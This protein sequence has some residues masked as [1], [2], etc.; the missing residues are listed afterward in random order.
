M[1]TYIK[2]NT[3]VHRCDSRAKIALL[4]AY[5][6]AIFFVSSWWA[7]LGF[8]AAVVV[9]G[10]AARLPFGLMNRMLVPV[11]VLAGFSVLFNVIAAPIVGGLL[12]GLFL[13]LRMVLLVA[14]SFVVC[15]TSSS[16]DLLEAF[17]WFIGPLGRVHVPVDDVAFT[18]SLALRFIPLVEREYGQIR[19]AQKARGADLAASF[20]DKLRIAG[21][22]FAAM[23]VNLFRRA[24]TM[25]EAM[26]SRCY[27][28]AVRTR[29]P[30]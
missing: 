19:T 14:A 11:Y 24:D 28:A 25:A 15:L 30:R 18:L 12:A 17:R 8:A 26:D 10:V 6:I 7:M 9:A 13:A 3:P 1:L 5:S 27:G 29:L 21:F 16:T 4:F 22:A 2:G 23:F 20:F